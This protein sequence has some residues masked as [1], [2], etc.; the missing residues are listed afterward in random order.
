MT[1]VHTENSENNCMQSTA[2]VQGKLTADRCFLKVFF[3][4]FGDI[5]ID[6]AFS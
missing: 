3:L 6:N 4:W 1:G 5:L 2:N